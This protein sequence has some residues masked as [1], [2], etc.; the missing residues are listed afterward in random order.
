MK[1]AKTTRILTPIT[2]WLQ[3]NNGQHLKNQTQHLID[4]SIS[5]CFG[6]HLLKLGQLSAQLKT[7]KCPILHQINCAEKGPDIGLRSNLHDLPFQESTIDLC[8][9]LHELDFSSDPHQLLREIDRVLTLDGTLIISGFNP[10]SLFACKSLFTPQN[11]KNVRLF[12]PNRV[13][14]WLHLLGFEIQQK[15]F[16]NCNY[17]QS[18]GSTLSF[19]QN[20]GQGYFPFL[21]SV[22]FIVAKKQSTPLTRIKSNIK[23]R[24][25]IINSRPVTTKQSHPKQSH[26]KKPYESKV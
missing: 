26:S 3:F 8:I 17:P 16:F 2:D 22:Y 12:S 25:T 5:R 19:L 6:Y 24:K 11:K 10:Y 9:L 15:Q 14:D 21:C 4:N 20:I 7:D 13:I 23:F 18:K 1:I